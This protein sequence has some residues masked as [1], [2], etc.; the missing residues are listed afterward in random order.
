MKEVCEASQQELQQLAE[1]HQEQMQDMAQL[2][3]KLQV[4]YQ[5]QYNNHN[6]IEENSA[7][8]SQVDTWIVA[9]SILVEG[10]VFK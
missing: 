4:K 1:K 10:I 3:E 8:I 5:P 9:R 6:L 2:Q 7:C